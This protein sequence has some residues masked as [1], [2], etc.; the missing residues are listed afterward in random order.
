MYRVLIKKILV[1]LII[2][3]LY[4]ITSI[5]RGKN[6]IMN[7]VKYKKEITSKE[8]VLHSIIHER[9]KIEQLQELLNNPKKNLDVLEELLRQNLQVSKEN[10]ALILEKDW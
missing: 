10:E 8:I 1:L 2:L 9:N 7:F 6:S 3:N 4:F 5:F